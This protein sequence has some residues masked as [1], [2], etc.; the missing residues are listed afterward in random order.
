MIFD[1]QEF[2]GQSSLLKVDQFQ[3]GEQELRKHA[4]LATE[5]RSKLTERANS[6]RRAEDGT[7]EDGKDGEN[8]VKLELKRGY[9]STKRQSETKELLLGHDHQARRTKRSRRGLAQINAETR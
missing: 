1:P 3:M 5:I 9:T 6:L 8:E 4:R 2:E 7:A